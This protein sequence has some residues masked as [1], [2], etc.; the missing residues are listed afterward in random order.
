MRTC[1]WGLAAAL[2][3]AGV[4]VGA[5]ALPP[6]LG[7]SEA[8][9]RSE[10]LRSVEGGAVNY[11]V[12]RKAFKAVDGAARA[13][14]ATAAIA[15][16]RAYTAS[17]AFQQAYAAQRT[18]M[19]PQPPTFEGTPEEELAKQ[20]AAQDKAREESRKQIAAMPPE[21]RKMME[22]AMAAAAQ[23]LKQMDTPEMRKMMLDGIRMQREGQVTRH[24]E[25]MK[26]WETNYPMDPKPL[27]AKR[28]QAFL[29]LSGSVDYGAKLEPRDGMMRF[30][31]PA[32]ER[33]P[34]N[35]KLCYRAGRE[36]VE[37][38]RATATAWLAELR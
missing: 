3:M 37:A 12:A 9:A 14:L 36:T 28:L 8:S 25:E 2:M 18:A 38:A 19:K 11:G 22:E 26:T 4:V 24:A 1:V 23:A 32:L 29:D 20:R 30:V 33:K 21:Q 5:Q 16:A 15:W 6:Q 35:W 7:M 27:I 31:D 10:A 17:P 34:A 13:Q